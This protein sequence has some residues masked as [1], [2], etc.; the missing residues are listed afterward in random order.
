[1]RYIQEIQQTPK[2]NCCAETLLCLA[3]PFALASCVTWVGYVGSSFDPTRN[4]DVYVDRSAIDKSFTI[5]GKGYVQYAF[6]G[7]SPESI[8]RKAM[9]KAK[10]N[11]ADAVLIEDRVLAGNDLTLIRTGDSLHPV[12]Q[13]SVAPTAYTSLTV[14]FLRYGNR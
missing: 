4:V 13:G 7:G 2:A 1:M 6:L 12:F 10:A 3:L 11:G 5:V 14:Y 9:K 8:Q